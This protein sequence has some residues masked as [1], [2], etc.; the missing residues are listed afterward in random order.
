MPKHILSVGNCSYDYSTLSQALKEKF[1]VALQNADTAHDA[2]KAIANHQ[3]DLIL[4]NRLF[5]I[6]QD[7]GIALIKKLKDQKLS[8]PLMLISNFPESQTEAVSVG[9]VRGFGKNAVGKPEMLELVGKY[10]SK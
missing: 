10:L 8:T 2:E 1:D 7:S 5:D 4:V 3:F 6:N 9:A